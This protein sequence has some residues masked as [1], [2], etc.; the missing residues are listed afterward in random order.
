MNQSKIAVRYAKALFEIAIEKNQLEEIKSDIDKVDVISQQADVKLMLESPV[1]KSSKKRQLFNEIFQ[2]N[3]QDITLKF[4]LMIVDN[5]REI[6]LS[7]ICR[8][9]IEQ[10]RGYKG[11][12]SAKIITASVLDKEQI[13]QVGKVISEVFKTEVDLISS[14]DESLIGGF[15]IRVGDQQIDASVSHKLDNIKREF[16]GKTV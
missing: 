12:K 3:I 15:I 2:Q 8:N 10:Y 16:L 7:A 4:V 5:K 11:I 1:V 13:E 6:H 14:E 9:F